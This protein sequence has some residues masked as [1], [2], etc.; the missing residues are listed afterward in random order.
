VEFCS[1]EEINAQNSIP[2][3]K[4][5]KQIL[6][7]LLQTI[8]WNRKQLGGGG[9]RGRREGGEGRGEKGGGGGTRDASCA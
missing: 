7:I 3:S 8:R 5:R 9:G 6:K 2:W 4:K 1:E